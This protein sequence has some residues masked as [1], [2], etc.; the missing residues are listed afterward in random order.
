MK[1]ITAIILALVLCL[2]VLAF[3]GCG[4]AG[5]QTGGAGDGAGSAGTDTGAGT[6]KLTLWGAADDQ[7]MLREM[8]AVFSEDYDDARV[9]IEVRVTGEDVARDE[10]LKDI[11]T[12]ADVFAITNDQLGALVNADAVYENTRHAQDIRD[13]VT[14]SA[15]AAATIG[16]KLYGYPSSAE[17]YFLFYDKSKLSAEEVRSLEAIL[18]KEQE[19]GVAP[20]AMDFGDAYF[21]SSF[22]LTAGCRVYGE[23]GQ[24]ASDVSFASEEGMA[25]AR[26]IAS[27]KAQGAEDISGD[28][29]ASRFKSGKLAAYIS[30]SWKTAA[31][32][33]ALGANFGVAKLPTIDIGGEARDMVS[34]AGGKMYVVKSTTRHPVEAMALA[35]FLTNE[36]NQLKRFKERSI[37][38]CNEELAENEEVRS[39]VAIAAELEQLAHTVATPAISQMSKYWAPVG[40]FTKDAFDGKVSEEELQGKLEQLV[41][42]ITASK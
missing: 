30:G 36:E 24:D 17:T 12:A 16:G 6:V 2:S 23:D 19:E 7:Q 25:A 10:A 5:G 9:S 20:F 21:A 14:D 28:A 40:A 29:A 15:Y 39:N 8:A 31:F 1:K 37:L 11:E 35:E 38:P 41:S 34:F 42:D 22:F 3:A 13:E 27:L 26:Y 4:C 33:E 32:A 18:A